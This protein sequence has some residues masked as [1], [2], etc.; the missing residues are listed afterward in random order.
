MKLIS[1]AENLGFKNFHLLATSSLNLQGTKSPRY[2]FLNFSNEC[3]SMKLYEQVFGFTFF[4]QLPI[5]NRR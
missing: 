4:K 3:L 5:Y 2:L 1:T